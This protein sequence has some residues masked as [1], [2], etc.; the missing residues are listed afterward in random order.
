MVMGALLSLCC[1]ALTTCFG[2][3]RWC[4]DYTCPAELPTYEATS[5]H[6]RGLDAQLVAQVV[7]EIMHV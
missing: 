5:S 3:K 6:L 7:A 2:A 4:D 1:I